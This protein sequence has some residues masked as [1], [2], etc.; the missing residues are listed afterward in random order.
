MTCSSA[1]A[2]IVYGHS[3]TQIPFRQGALSSLARG[4]DRLSIGYQNMLLGEI[5]NQG[6]SNDPRGGY[7]VKFAVAINCRS[8]LKHHAHADDDHP[9]VTPS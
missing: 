9:N 4:K 7:I 5:N 1:L 3:H 2:E 6:N 8:T